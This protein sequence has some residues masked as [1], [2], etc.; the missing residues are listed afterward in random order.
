MQEN[1]LPASA[2]VDPN[3]FTDEAR[4]HGMLARLRRVDPLPH[5]Q[6]DGF[7]P[8]WLVTRHED[9]TAIELDPK[10][11]LNAPRQAI[12]PLELERRSQQMTG[13]PSSE[14]MRN[15]VAM[16]GEE[17]RAYRA[18]AQSRFLPSAL[19]NMRQS[20]EALASES[21]QKMAKLGQQCDF[22]GDI[23]KW[24]P[25]R[26]IMSL[27][28]VPRQ[29][30]E[31]MLRLTQQI[32]SGQDPEFA[33][34]GEGTNTRAMMEMAQYFAPFIKDRRSNPRDDLASVV[35]NATIDGQLLADRDVFGYFLIIAT[36]GHDTTSYSLAGGLLALLENPEQMARL[37]ADPTLLPLAVD[38]M[39]RWC[40][41][42]R[43]F[44]RTATENRLIRGS[45]IKAGDVVLLSYPSANRDEAVFK[46]PFEF[47]IDRKPNRHLA[48]GTGPHVCLGQHLAKIE[49]V[50]FLREL[51][52]RVDTVELAGQP[53]YVASAFVGGVKE[54]PI[55]YRVRKLAQAAP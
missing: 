11:F 39:I 9:I 16:D 18:I 49:L 35:A 14:L 7:A 29:D 5:V 1:D 28:G 19:S 52:A 45:Q 25:L 42:V 12:F 2:V 37:R 13:K 24:Y 43:Q 51:L 33:K 36:A 47:R 44:C 3:T 27:F 31:L 48:F 6:A 4:L 55:R 15:V 22:A 26:V 10:H 50:T 21:V 46:D 17:H 34:S 40:T 32:L 38:E 53:R 54:L 8:F 41:P 30:E 20:I 23:A